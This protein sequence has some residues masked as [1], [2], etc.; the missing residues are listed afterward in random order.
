[1]LE[2]VDLVSLEALQEVDINLLLLVV[3]AALEQQQDMA[4][5][6]EDKLM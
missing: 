2:E 1:M 6:E 5:P 3:A 4:E